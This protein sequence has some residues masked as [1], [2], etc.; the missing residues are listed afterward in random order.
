MTQEQQEDGVTGS[1]LRVRGS[2]GVRSVFRTGTTATTWSDGGTGRAH[3]PAMVGAG[4]QTA[5]RIRRAHEKTF[6]V[7]GCGRKGQG[8][9]ED[10]PGQTW[11]TPPLILFCLKC[12]FG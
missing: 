9:D 11:H 2:R 5:T 6:I 4:D 8:S 12:F 3:L 1:V 7:Q 10:G